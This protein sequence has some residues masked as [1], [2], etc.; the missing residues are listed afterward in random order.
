MADKRNTRN[1]RI[2]NSIKDYFT[3]T[4]S[5][6]NGIR[7]LLV[8][9]IILFGCL[10]YTQFISPPTTEVDI[11]AFEKEIKQFEASLAPKKQIV[12]PVKDS[13][14]ILPVSE[15]EMPAELFA[16]NPNNL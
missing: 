3:F 14:N 9:L 16:F 13:L 6:R 5:E 11:I 4:K 12:F 1:N 8:I 15:K 7:V 10:Y 2:K